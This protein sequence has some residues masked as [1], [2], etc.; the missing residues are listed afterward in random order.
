MRIL[1]VS[2]ELEGAM[3]LTYTCAYGKVV[4]SVKG[5]RFQQ[6]GVDATK[7]LQEAP[8]I[9]HEEARVFRVGL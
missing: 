7:F 9:H 4:R 6:R 8:H 1:A 3:L 2:K 5:G